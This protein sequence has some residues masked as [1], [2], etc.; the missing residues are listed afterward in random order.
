M[1]KTLGFGLAL[2]LAMAAPAA[3]EMAKG[4][5]KEV[6]KGAQTIVLEDGTRLWI[7][8]GYINE[9]AAGD[10]VQVVYETRG[11]KKAVTEIDRRA[12]LNDGTESSNFG[13]R[14]N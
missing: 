12:T 6:D 8:N 5:V 10:T 14:G 7:S 1:G 3:A 2:L 13:A 11:D 9:L 4:K